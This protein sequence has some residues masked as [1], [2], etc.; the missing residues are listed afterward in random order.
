MAIQF[1]ELALEERDSFSIAVERQNRKGESLPALAREDE[2]PVVPRP[3]GGPNNRTRLK[4]KFIL[5]GAVGGF[6]INPTAAG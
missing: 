1:V 4:E 3:V 6:P 5:T 2:E